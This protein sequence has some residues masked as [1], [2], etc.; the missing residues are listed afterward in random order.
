MFDY[1][2]GITVGSIAA[3]LATSLESDWLKPLTAMIV[4]GLVTV[5]ISFATQKSI[6]LR[7]LFTGKELILYDNGEIFIKNL[8]SAS[9]DINDFLT[10]CR[11]NGF[12]DLRDIQTAI[13]E[14]NGKISFIPKNTSRP[15]NP[16]DI[17][18]LPKQEKYLTD[19]IIDGKILKENLSKCGRDEKWLKNR[20]KESNIS[21]INE[22]LLACFDGKDKI[23]FYK[24]ISAQSRSTPFE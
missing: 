22:V 18:I 14:T 17:N 19:L 9:I 20:L 13:F 11:L 5:L 24:K 15:V 8:K 7:R 21:N 10:Q 23:S 4:Y 12:F 6:K 16:A 2:N 1:I 3:E